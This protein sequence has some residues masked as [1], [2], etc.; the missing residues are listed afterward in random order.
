[1]FYICKIKNKNMKYEYKTKV[2]SF[3][4]INNLIERLYTDGN[5]TM[6][7]FIVLASA[8]SASAKDI[9][10]L[11]WKDIINKN[12]ITIDITQSAEMVFTSYV[13]DYIINCYNSISP[14]STSTNIFLSRK[15]TCY[16]IQRMN[17]MLKKL[18]V[19]YNLDL[20][21]ISTNTFRLIGKANRREISHI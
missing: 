4:E 19:K 14:N 6:S 3:A 16:S 10:R 12:G 13:K 5:Y 2:L 20:N 15:H 9:L 18:I 8:T 7:L 21:T 1:M 17:V 11:K